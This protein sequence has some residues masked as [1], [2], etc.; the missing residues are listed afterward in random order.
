MTNPVAHIHDQIM[1]QMP[2]AYSGGFL[3]IQWSEPIDVWPGRGVV[4]HFSWGNY[5]N[6]FPFILEWSDA[7]PND[8]TQPAIPVTSPGWNQV[9]IKDGICNP[10]GVGDPVRFDSDAAW[11][12][13]VTS[14]EVPVCPPMRFLRWKLLRNPIIDPP[15][16]LQCL[17]AEIHHLR[18]KEMRG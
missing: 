6:G 14:V 17:L 3:A 1:L 15:T 11:A 5:V 9:Y 4:F 8:D 12:N 7:D 18:T 13:S 2:F 10:S 16:G